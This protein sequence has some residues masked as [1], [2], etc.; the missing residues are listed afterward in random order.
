MKKLFLFI[1]ILFGNIG[2]M[3]LADSMCG[4]NGQF[5][6]GSNT[7]RP[8]QY[9]NVNV[10]E[11]PGYTPSK[12]YLFIMPSLNSKNYQLIDLNTKDD[13]VA[14]DI[15]FGHFAYLFDEKNSNYVRIKARVNVNLKGYHVWVS[16]D[17]GRIFD[18]ISDKTAKNNCKEAGGKNCKIILKLTYSNLKLKDFRDNTTI[19]LKVTSTFSYN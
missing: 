1:L 12:Y 3:S 15:I 11:K 8:I 4:A 5:D 16:S 18:S 7:C 13:L 10:Y 2:L 14:R 9:Q 19:K 6:P 17:D